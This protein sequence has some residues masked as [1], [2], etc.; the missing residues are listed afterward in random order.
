[1]D[2]SYDESDGEVALRACATCAHHR[3]THADA[4]IPG[5][6]RVDPHAL[7]RRPHSSLNHLTPPAQPLRLCQTRSSTWTT[8]W[9]RR[10]TCGTSCGSPPARPRA[11]P[12]PSAPPA[13]S[14][15]ARATPRGSPSSSRTSSR[16]IST[17]SRAAVVRPV[18][19]SPTRARVS[20]AAARRPA[21]PRVAG[22]ATHATTQ[23]IERLQERHWTSCKLLPSYAC[24]CSALL[25]AHSRGG[26]S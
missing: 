6:A 9:R 20:V 22:K 26:P 25:K 14:H 7:L 12:L 18:Q 4:R 15:P 24:L 1:M 8:A 11:C 2:V 3:T 21:S 16:S 10:S 5:C 13:P 17:R 19:R 23:P